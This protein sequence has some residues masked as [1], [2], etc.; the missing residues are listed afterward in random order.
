MT[1]SVKAHNNSQNP[2]KQQF[3]M[4][5]FDKLTHDSVKIYSSVRLYQKYDCISIKLTEMVLFWKTY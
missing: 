4:F 3:V 1:I 2:M 5:I